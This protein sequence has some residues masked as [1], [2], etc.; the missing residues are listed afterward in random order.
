MRVTL[1]KMFR[2]ARGGGYFM[3]ELK[4]EPGKACT[5]YLGHRVMDNEGYAFDV[6]A[7]GRIVKS[8]DSAGS[9]PV[10]SYK[11]DRIAIPAELMTDGR[12]TIKVEA[13]LMQ[14]STEIFDLKLLKD[15]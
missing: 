3:Y 4:G 13:R 11:A 1:N 2:Q 8:Y 5:L 9:T 7:N 14:Q 10:T 6:K 12:V 15:F